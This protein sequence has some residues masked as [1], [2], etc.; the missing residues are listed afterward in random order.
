MT[1]CKCITCGKE[2]NCPP[3][4]IKLGSGKYCCQKCYTES[5]KQQDVICYENNYAFILLKKDNIEYKVLFDIEDVEKIKQYK[6]H[7]HKGRYN[8][9]DACTNK[10]CSHKEKR[11]YMIMTRYLLDYNGEK[12]IDHINRNTLDNR[13]QNLRIVDCWSNNQNKQNDNNWRGITWDKARN[14]WKATLQYNGRVY[15]LGRFDEFRDALMRRKIA[16]RTI[17]KLETA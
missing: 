11:R 5:R 4:R 14:K 8:R 1:I 3:S 13:R 10:R 12:Q 9:V 6:W 7:I 16:E 15:N 17:V 2:F